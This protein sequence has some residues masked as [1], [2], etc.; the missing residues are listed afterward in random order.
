MLLPLSASMTALAK[1]V[2]WKSLSG[3]LMN[4][5]AREEATMAWEHMARALRAM[6]KTEDF[7]GTGG[8]FSG[9][10]VL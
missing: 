1:G 2:T 9:S 3:G 6:E 8:L 5:S 7:S 10:S 4:R